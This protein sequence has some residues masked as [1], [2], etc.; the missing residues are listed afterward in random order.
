M[1]RKLFVLGLALVATLAFVAR[2][3]KPNMSKESLEKVATHVV[4][5]EV[6]AI[7]EYTEVN[8]H[9]HDRTNYVAECRVERSEKGKGLEAEGLVYVRYWHYGPW[10]GSQP[11][12]AGT[13]GHRGLPTIGETLRIY[14][15]RN[16]YDGFSQDKDNGD[17]GYNVIGAN[18]FERLPKPEDE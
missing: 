13:M 9:G 5:A 18:G 15:A 16:A 11:G 10:K 12:P 6:M 14:L 7:Y 8:P 1:T 4:V 17:G 2:A 3:E